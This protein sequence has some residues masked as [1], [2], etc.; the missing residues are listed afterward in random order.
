MSDLATFNPFDPAALQCPFPHY[1]QMRE[2]QPVMHLES[3]GMY[4]VTRHD[5]VLQIIRDV[6]TYSSRFGG[7]SMPLPP[8]DRAKLD[9]V[10]AE[11]YPRIPTMLTADMP[12]HTRYRRLISKAF[13]PKVIA[14]LEPKIR[15]ITTRLIDAFIDNGSM[16]FV[17]EFGVPL[18]VEVIAYALNVPDDRLADFKRW[19]DD[20]IAGIGT[21]ISIEQ[22]MEAERGVNE[23]Q[24][25][26][27]AELEKRK[28]EP[29]DDLLTNLLNAR[30]DDDDPD[31]TDKRP[32]DMAE[33]LSMVQ[34]LLV[35]GNETTTKLLTESMR[36]IAETPGEWEKLRA[37]PARAPKMVEEALRLTTPTQGMF[38]I[39]T[40]DHELEGVQIPK[41]ARIVIVFASANR[42]TDLFEDPD[43]FCPERD[44]LRDHL[45]FGKGIHFCLGAAL[46][47]LE[48]K[49]AL[50]ELSRRIE[51]FSLPESNDY[52]YFP[53]FLLRGLTRL[54]VDFTPD[55][56]QLAGT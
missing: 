53:S 40:K 47:R 11:G 27:A 51:S 56:T 9:E 37:D 49:V 21:Q 50:E 24:A 29:Q 23:Y 4:L 45:A 48:G 28:S 8:D 15:E 41:G 55:A 17:E 52:S 32:L 7:A 26:F 5:L 33:M 34:Q 10:M 3:M 1:A 20:S 35:A 36:L 54:D 42:D 43:S 19:S 46:S 39:S 22:R 30:I 2:E 14:E 12:D 44:N 38:R 18:P 25:Y 6:E 13:T 16:E 31:I